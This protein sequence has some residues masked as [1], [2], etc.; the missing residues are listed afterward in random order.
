[1]SM[2]HEEVMAHAQRIG[3][4]ILQNAEF[5]SVYEDEEL[6]YELEEDQRRVWE[7]LTSMV[8]TTED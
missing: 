3:D 8:T 4:E 7:A 5:C 1:M 6:E 2:T